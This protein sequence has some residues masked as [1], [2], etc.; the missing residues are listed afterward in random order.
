MWST[1][2]RAPGRQALWPAGSAAPQH[3]GS[4]RTRA[5]PC[6]PCISSRVLQHW[7]TRRAQSSLLPRAEFAW[8]RVAELTI[9]ELQSPRSWPSLVLGWPW[10]G[11]AP[12]GP[13]SIPTSSSSSHSAV[14]TLPWQQLLQRASLH[15]G[16]PAASCRAALRS[17]VHRWVLADAARPRCGPAGRR[18]EPW[19]GDEQEYSGGTFDLAVS[20]SLHF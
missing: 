17:P 12:Q 20:A 15:S 18:W 9:P 1:G 13:L 7:T 19:L 14:R 16:G 8:I 2:S 10:P 6:V 3:A 4:S 11:L 5:E